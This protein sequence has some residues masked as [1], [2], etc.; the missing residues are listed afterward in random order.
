[1]SHAIAP[2]NPRRLTARSIFPTRARLPPAADHP[3]LP[4]HATVRHAALFRQGKSSRQVERHLAA[5]LHA[6]MGDLALGVACD[7]SKSATSTSRQVC[8]GNARP[9]FSGVPGLRIDQVL[10]EAPADG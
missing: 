6:P 5:D 7:L 2:A 8:R 9:V 10:Q 3:G 1:M 4:G